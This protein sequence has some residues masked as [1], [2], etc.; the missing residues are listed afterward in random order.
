M[1]GSR[2][3]GFSNALLLGTFLVMVTLSFFA[4]SSSKLPAVA[5][6][7]TVVVSIFVEEDNQGILD[8]IYEVEKLTPEI[9]IEE[10]ILQLTIKKQ[11]EALLKSDYIFISQRDF[12]G[13]VASQSFHKIGLALHRGKYFEK[14]DPDRSIG[15]FSGMNLADSKSTLTVNDLFW[16]DPGKYSDE[17][18]AEDGK[19]GN[20]D[21]KKFREFCFL[22]GLMSARHCHLNVEDEY[23]NFSDLGLDEYMTHSIKYCN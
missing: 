8:F 10:E 6:C 23:R 18:V 22:H 14:V 21:R 2:K 11:E 3:K 19:H 4:F 16:L 13:G 9:C 15:C 17:V 1:F 5:N 7:E 20:F 12:L